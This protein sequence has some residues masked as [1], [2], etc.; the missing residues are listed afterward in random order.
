[1]RGSLIDMLIAVVILASVAVA[2]SLGVR[3]AM[4]PING[5]VLLASQVVIGTSV[6]LV[7]SSLLYRRLHVRPLLLPK[8]PL[9][10]DP[11]RHYLTV[12]WSWPV[13]RVR[14]CNCSR[15]V[16][17]HLDTFDESSSE[18][19]I[20]RIKLLWPYSFG[21]RWRTVNEHPHDVNSPAGQ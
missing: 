19:N 17:L 3:S 11:D 1:M 15:D 16:E 5:A 4:L 9:C 2:V 13:E 18:A 8:C 12:S 7:V 6:Y 10:G 20:P 14:C 21:G